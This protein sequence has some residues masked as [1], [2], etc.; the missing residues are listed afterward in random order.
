MKQKN[1]KKKRKEIGK[2]QERTIRK[3]AKRKQK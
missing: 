1:V 2:K 3:S